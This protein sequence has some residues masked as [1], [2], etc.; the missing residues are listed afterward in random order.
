MY[1]IKVLC[2]NNFRNFLH[3]LGRYVCGDRQLE[4]ETK[5]ANYPQTPSRKWRVCLLNEGAPTLQLTCA[6]NPSFI[7]FHVKKRKEKKKSFAGF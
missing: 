6:Y 7:K 4:C 2:V 3:V 5:N 1:I